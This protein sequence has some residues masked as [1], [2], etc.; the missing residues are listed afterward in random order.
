V[1]GGS[2]K[3]TAS[4]PFTG[5]DI[6]FT[7]RASGGRNVLYAITLASPEGGKVDIHSIPASY[8]VRSV[9]LLGSRAHLKWSQ[10]SGGLAIQIPDAKPCLYACAFKILQ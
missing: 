3:D 2:F 9:Q 6:R 4:K 8:K 7:T 10:G 1:V 5:Q